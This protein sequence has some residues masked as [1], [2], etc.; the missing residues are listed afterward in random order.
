MKKIE[1]ILKYLGNNIKK[2]RLRRNVTMETLAQ[3]A[4]ISIPTLRNIENG[5]NISLESLIKI[6]IELQLEKDILK[7]AYS[8][9]EGRNLQD[10]NLKKR[11]K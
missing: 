9:N 7:I 6:L 2:A 5:K 8:D 4:N 3:N 10:N 1:P 11:A